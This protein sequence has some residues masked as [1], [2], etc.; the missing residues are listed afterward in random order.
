MD[1]FP[2]PLVESAEAWVKAP[3]WHPWKVSRARTR[4]GKS[5]P[6]PWLVIHEVTVRDGKGGKSRVTMLPEFPKGFLREHP[7]KSSGFTRKTSG[8]AGTGC[9]CRRL[10]EETTRT[11][12]ASGARVVF[13]QQKGWRNPV[14]SLDG[15][16]DVHESIVHKAFKRAV[17]EAGLTRRAPCQRLRHSFVHPLESRSDSRGVHEL[18]VHKDIRTTV[19][20]TDVVN[21]GGRGVR[22]PIDALWGTPCRVLSRNRIACFP[23]TLLLPNSRLTSSS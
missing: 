13:L 20:Y 8:T 9:G 11:P 23:R 1:S 3:G 10:S 18:L 2:S 19:V 17:R 14:T 6:F 4:H 21:R 22:S 16:H 12:Q 7:K 15:R 5:R